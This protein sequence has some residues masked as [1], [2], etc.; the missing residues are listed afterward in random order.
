MD[1]QTYL[2]NLEKDLNSY[3]V[4]EA[5]RNMARL[6]L[7]DRAQEVADFNSQFLK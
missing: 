6:H 4:T 3:F 5:G 1:P 7:A 2:D